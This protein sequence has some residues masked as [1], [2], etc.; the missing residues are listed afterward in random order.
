M[1]DELDGAAVGFGDGSTT[2]LADPEVPGHTIDERDDA[3]LVEGAED[4]VAFE[5]TDAAPVLS[6]WRSLGDVA[7]AG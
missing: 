3:V 2:E 4:G 5:V 6:S 1:V 7:L